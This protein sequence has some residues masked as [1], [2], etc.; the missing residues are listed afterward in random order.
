MPEP[1]PVSG[2]RSA[3]NLR[4]ISVDTPPVCDE[5]PTIRLRR[6]QRAALGFA[7]E[8]AHLAGVVVG[9]W[10]GT[11]EDSDP[12]ELHQLRVALRRSRSVLRGGRSVFADETLERFEDELRWLAGLTG[13]T[14]DLDLF[15]DGWPNYTEGLD[16]R[17]I[18]ALL[19]VSERLHRH[20]RDAFDGLTDGMESERAVHLV[21]AWTAELTAI[22]RGLR[23]VGEDGDRRLGRVVGKR[24]RA[25]H[26]RLIKDG[27]R[28]ADDS[29]QTALHELRKEAK[30]LRYLIECFGGAL[31]KTPGKRF[32]RRLKA[33]QDD[34]GAIQDG[35]VH[36][37][38]LDLIAAELDREGA[39]RTTMLAVSRLRQ[40]IES[41]ATQARDEF[42]KRFA[43]FDANKTRRI[44][45]QLVA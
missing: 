10:D 19:P 9:H 12:E 13:P 18:V 22:Q 39:S 15:I 41:A 44:L 43:A 30:R 28:I 34:L 1:T 8:L 2:T 24:I 35:A 21:A 3:M 38:E 32:S 37:A 33:L 29:P 36:R 40:Q 4:S 23:T 31:P 26:R 16:T 17:T 6:G 27:R 42:A 14:R 5:S 11:L 25:A 7:A 20:R 45:A